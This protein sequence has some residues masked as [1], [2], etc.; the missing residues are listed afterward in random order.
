MGHKKG[1]VLAGGTGSRLW[2]TTIP[3]S[4]QL[5]PVYDKPMIYYPLTTLMLAGIRQVLIITTPSDVE[6]Y[7]LLLGDGRQWGIEIQ[8]ALQPRPDGIAQAF[9]IGAE[10]IGTDGCALALGDNIFYG[11]GLSERLQ[12]AAA[13]TSG[14]TVFG[15]WVRDPQRYGVVELNDRRQAIDIVEKPH[16]PRSNWAVTGLYFYDASVLDIAASVRPSHRRELEITDVNRAYLQRS[17]LHVEVL[18]RGFAWLDAGTHESLLRSSEFICTIEQRQG[19]KIGCPEEIAFRM[20][21]IDAE[22]L[23][24]L[25]AALG[26]GEY[27]SYLRRML[28]AG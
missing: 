4:K 15:Y 5:L 8:Y 28:T 11:A 21:F 1:I 24:K 6:R 10:F 20:G 3:I 19:L 12:A 16:A 17:T 22:A 14:A 2:P 23:E 27:A 18:S 26:N 7:K 25:A 13:R 9:L